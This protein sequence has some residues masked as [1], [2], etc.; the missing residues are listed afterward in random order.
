[1]KILNFNSWNKLSEATTFD[2]NGNYT[3]KTFGFKT[4]SID[5]GFASPGGDGGDWAGSMPRALAVAKAADEFLGGKFSKMSFSQKRSK[6]KTAS[7]HVSDHYSGQTDAYAVDLMCSQQEGDKL[8]P[9]LMQWIGKPGTP[10]G[11]W[12]NIY[13]NGY[14]YQFGWKTP[15][16]MHNDHIHVG[17][18]KD[19]GKGMQD[20]LGGSS[21]LVRINIPL[22]TQ[23]ELTPEV[24]GAIAKI[25]QRLQDGGYFILP[26]IPPG[27]NT[28][29]LGIG[30][31]TPFFISEI[32]NLQTKNN[33]TT[34]SN[35]IGPLTYDALDKIQST[36]SNQSQESDNTTTVSA[37]KD[38]NDPTFISSLN[39]LAK[40]WKINANDLLAI[41]FSE[42]G[43]NPK[44][45]NKSSGA[46]G[47]IQFIPS[48]AKSLGTSTEAL[49]KMSRSEQLEWVEKYLKANKL[50]VG[51]TAGQIYAAIFMPANIHKDS[52][53]KYPSKAYTA[54]SGLDSNKDKEITISDLSA[55]VDSMK[56]KYGL[57]KDSNVV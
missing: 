55:R 16:G 51:A 8:W 20:K 33:I 22:T 1:V 52:L 21:S 38:L 15:E 12:V 6:V 5:S 45:V 32:R 11:Q 9:F 31:I 34:E 28:L 13:K 19:D 50:P 57:D 36:D 46:T 44:A 24:S 53:A 23:V 43:L 14:R 56:K 10:W 39:D 30:R 18:R 4:G 2:P 37:I 7:G 49:S 25:Q 41:M 42:S 17:V 26:G 27:V 48:T 47:L 3:D 29:D 54:N 40:R 35:E